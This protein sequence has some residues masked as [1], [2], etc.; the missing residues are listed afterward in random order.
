MGRSRHSISAIAMDIGFF[1]CMGGLR[2]KKCVASNYSTTCLHP[3]GSDH[4]YVRLVSLIHSSSGGASYFKLLSRLPLSGGTRL[5]LR[6]EPAFTLV[7]VDDR[8]GIEFLTGHVEN[9]LAGIHADVA[10][11]VTTE[12]Q[13]IDDWSPWLTVTAKQNTAASETD[14]SCG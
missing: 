8:L 9:A 6:A 5:V 1:I 4:F 12:S 13:S 10:L 3:A 11:N 7:G 2:P 14:C